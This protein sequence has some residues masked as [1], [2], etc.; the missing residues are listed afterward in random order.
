MLIQKC[1]PFGAV[2]GLLA[3][4]DDAFLI[5][6]SSHTSYRSTHLQLAPLQTPADDTFCD[7]SLPYSDR[8]LF[9]RKSAVSVTG[10]VL[11]SFPGYANADDVLPTTTISCGGNFDGL[12]DLPRI[13]PGCARLYLCRHGQ[14]E[15][16]RLH[17]VQGARV[18]P[19]INNNGVE[20][21]TRLGMSISR[22]AEANGGDVGKDAI[23]TLVAHSRMRRARETAQALTYAATSASL[24]VIGIE[25]S[26]GEVDFGELEG[27]DAKKARMEMMSTFAS[28]SIGDIDRRLSGGESGREVLERAIT[29]LEKLSHTAATSTSSSSMLAVSHSTYL[30]VLLSLINDT[31]LA[32]SAFWKIQNG[33]INVVDVNINGKTREVTFKSGIFGGGRGLGLLPR[34]GTKDKRLKLIMPE[35]YLIR[36]NE[37]R[38]LDGMDV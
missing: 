1:I 29:A 31:P 19:S 33:S 6:P 35:A 10:S 36:T 12:L 27:T 23:P 15:N 25:T 8:R 3:H 16:N 32:Q 28:W 26:L 11:S 14:T 17:L 4:V 37:V 9:L 34:G 18:D 20:Q 13:T 38:H 22:L 2:C 30:K 24:K 7:D 21:A 5:H